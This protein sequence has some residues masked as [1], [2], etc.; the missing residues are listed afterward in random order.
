MKANQKYSITAT[1]RTLS[2]GDGFLLPFTENPVTAHV[3]A[4][5][6][7]ASVR[8]SKGAKGYSVMLTGM[9][10]DRIEKIAYPI[11]K[12]M[13]LPE[14]NRGRPT[15]IAAAAKAAKSKGKKAAPKASKAPAKKSAPA[16]ATKR[17]A[18]KKVAKAAKVAPKR[19][20]LGGKSV[21][22]PAAPFVK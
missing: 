17:P 7:G 22:A 16:K 10:K 19:V 20:N 18:A 12:G 3:A 8:V 6:L 9:P 15:L 11:I 2:K 4:R 13:K 1:L 5:Q 14:S 21:I